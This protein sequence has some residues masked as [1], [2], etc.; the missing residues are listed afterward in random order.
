[1]VQYLRT[2]QAPASPALAETMH[3]LGKDLCLKRISEQLDFL[4]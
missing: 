4:K 3:V 2:T 1:M